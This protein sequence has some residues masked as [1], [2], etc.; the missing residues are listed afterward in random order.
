MVY[1]V[2]CVTMRV[3]IAVRTPAVTNDRSA[4][5][6]PCIYN[7]HQSV[8]GSVRN[9]NE[10]RSPGLALNTAKHPLPLNTVAPAV[11]ALTELALV[12]LY[13]LARTADLL[14]TALHVQEHGLS[15]ELAPVRERI[16]TEAMLSFDKVG[17]FVE[18]DV[19]C[20][21]QSL[22]ES[23]VAMLKP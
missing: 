22:L 13:G 6:D 9:G 10:K 7:G 21:K 12:D 4:G 17:R 15:A 19:V 11:F 1:G 5:F 3:E 2:V 20:E 18:Y 8:G 16:S 23:E 14:R